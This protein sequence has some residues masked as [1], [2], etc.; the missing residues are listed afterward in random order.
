M[1]MQPKSQNTYDSRH[2][3]WNYGLMPSYLVLNQSTM[4]RTICFGPLPGNLWTSSSRWS[5]EH[6]VSPLKSKPRRLS[7]F[8]KQHVLLNFQSF[9]HESKNMSKNMFIYWPTER[10]QRHV[11]R[12]ICNAFC[13]VYSSRQRRA[14]VLSGGVS[15]APCGTCA[16]PAPLCTPSISC[17]WDRQPEGNMF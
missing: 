4:H 16:P 8:D 1:K 13:I 9:L 5:P 6:L 15:F 11:H 3:L 7:A 2:E 14:A 17:A 10:A 12:T